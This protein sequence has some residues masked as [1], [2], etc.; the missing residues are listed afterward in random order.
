MCPS[1]LC[2]LQN[3]RR[4]VDTDQLFEVT[5]MNRLRQKR[6]RAE[7]IC[8]ADAFQ[9]LEIA[10]HDFEQFSEGGPASQER[11]NFKA[12]HRGKLQI[13]QQDRGYAV[14]VFGCRFSLRLLKPRHRFRAVREV[15]QRI[16]YLRLFEHLPQ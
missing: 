16:S 12:A 13:K 15:M 10:D 3:P 8:F 5:A 4:R 11:K 7:G 6:M 1:C 9:V 2:S 14:A